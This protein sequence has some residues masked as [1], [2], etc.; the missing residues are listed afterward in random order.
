MVSQI[1]KAYKEAIKDVELYNP[2]YNFIPLNAS[3]GWRNK[4]YYSGHYSF[5]SSKPVL[6]TIKGQSS[7]WYITFDQLKKNTEEIFIDYFNDKKK[8]DKMLLDYGRY[9]KIVNEYYDKF[10]THFINETEEAQLI[11]DLDILL[12]AEKYTNALGWFSIYFE[13]SFIEE[14]L[15][16]LKIQIDPQKLN[17]IIEK[18]TSPVFKSFDTRNTDAILDYLQQGLSLEEIAEKMIY[19]YA[20]FHGCDSLDKIYS[21][22]KNNYEKYLIDKNLLERTILKRKENFAEEVRKFE[23]WRRRFSKNEPTLIDYIQ[24]STKIR[25]ELRDYIGKSLSVLVMI[26]RLFLK[27]QGIPEEY[28][29]VCLYGEVLKG[30]SY[31]AKIKDDLKQRIGGFAVLIYPD[32]IQTELIDFD[33]VKADLNNYYLKQYGFN[34]NAQSNIIKGQIANKGKVSGTVKV[35][36]DIDRESQKLDNGDILVTGMT[37]P[38]FVPLMKRAG[39]IVTDEGGITS[40]AAIVSRELN[41]PCII[42]TKISTQVLKDGMRVEVDADKGVVTILKK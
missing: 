8:I 42:G 35:I 17:E 4:K 5:V 19:M 10:S 29:S 6:S 33:E 1:L 37:R 30:S 11:K 3:I 31:L 41:K 21:D 40:H 12:E 25:D 20:G 28:A 16:K 2:I 18:A 39:A 38:E 24:L 23:E 26:A 15:K 34:E 9:K 22:I 36:I 7:V 13:H 32:S 14:N 27:R